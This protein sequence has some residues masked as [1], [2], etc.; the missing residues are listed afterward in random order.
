MLVPG[1]EPYLSS[2]KYVC[3]FFLAFPI[4]HALQDQLRWPH[5]CILMREER[6]FQFINPHL[7]RRCSTSSKTLGIG[8][9]QGIGYRLPL[10]AQRFI[11]YNVVI[12]DRCGQRWQ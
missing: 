8:L 12:G 2:L 4:G 7:F 10:E 1:A 3:L 9:L 5:Y 11:N 6:F